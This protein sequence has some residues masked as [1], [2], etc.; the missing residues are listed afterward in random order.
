MSKMFDI[1]CKIILFTITFPPQHDYKFFINVLCVDYEDERY[2][3][4]KKLNT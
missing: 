1:T 4:D 2:Q 3:L